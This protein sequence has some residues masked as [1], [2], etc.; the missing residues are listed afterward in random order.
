M[1]MGT[2]LEIQKGIEADDLP[3]ELFLL[4]NAYLDAAVNLN[5]QLVLGDWK[6]TYQRGQVIM[7]LARHAVELCM[8]ACIKIANPIEQVK[9][10]NLQDLEK[11]LND[12]F[13]EIDYQIPFKAEPVLPSSELLE[14][15]DKNAK[16]AYEQL[17]YPM[18][19]NGVPWQGIFVFSAPLFKDSLKE[20][21]DELSRIRNYVESCDKKK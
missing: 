19:N 14:K 9:T 7:F 12:S 11:K 10:H 13:P 2:I 6:S 1:K 3:D 17:R 20:I 15:M 5:T 8:K 21:Q 18:D 16:V 4:S